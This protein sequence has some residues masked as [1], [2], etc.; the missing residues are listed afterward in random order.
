MALCIL[1][2]G[3]TARSFTIGGFPHPEK[4]LNYW[5]LKGVSPLTIVFHIL[6]EGEHI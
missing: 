3:T 1:R 4:G 2:E 6:G 5:N